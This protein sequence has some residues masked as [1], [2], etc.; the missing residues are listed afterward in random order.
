[1][2]NWASHTVVD[3]RTECKKRDLPIKG[4]KAELVARLE[5]ADNAQQNGTST[6]ASVD[7]APVPPTPLRKS[8][9]ST[10]NAAIPATSIKTNATATPRRS[11]RA[12]IA[13][14]PANEDSSASATPARG[15]P[16][17][18]AKDVKEDATAALAA[19]TPAKTP[20][21]RGSRTAVVAPSTTDRK[22]TRLTRRATSNYS[23]NQVTS[24]A[25]NPDASNDEKD[26]SAEVGQASAVQQVPTSPH[27]ANRAAA[28]GDHMDVDAKLDSIAP[29]N[30]SSNA[31]KIDTNTRT[32]SATLKQSASNG[33]VL[34]SA[35]RKLDDGDYALEASPKKAKAAEETVPAPSKTI[36]SPIQASQP[37]PLAENVKK[38]EKTET[39]SAA[40]VTH[41]PVELSILG[42]AT[43]GRAA[44]IPEETRSVAAAPTEAERPAC[45]PLVVEET[46]TSSNQTLMSANSN[47]SLL[48]AAS[49]ASF[50][51]QDV[52]EP[53]TTIWIKNFTRPLTIPAVKELLSPFGTVEKFW[54]DKIK[55]NCYVT[56]DS[57]EGATAAIQHCH[58]LKFPV[59][60]GRQLVCEYVTREQ[61]DEAIAAAEARTARPFTTVPPRSGFRDERFAASVSGAGRMSA[62][63][64]PP[65]AAQSGRLVQPSSV[66]LQE[67]VYTPPPLPRDAIPSETVF[68]KTKTHPP[69]Y[70]RPRTVTEVLQARQRRNDAQRPVSRRAPP[71]LVRDK[72]G[73]EDEQ[74]QHDSKKPADTSQSRAA[75]HVGAGGIGK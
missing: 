2:T 61:A 44:S 72:D 57:V 24:D 9:R 31:K 63:F 64:I 70:Y 54:M 1:M 13:A 28:D 37:T 46:R 50:A 51:N 41:T 74:R 47:A 16:S 45:A 67:P 25:S 30:H 22:S 7:T 18:A 66:T 29:S 38:G 40:I 15:N 6:T 14:T 58:G 23:E 35:K 49:T 26:L 11:S 39:A 48:T 19:A 56:Y 62:G 60:T 12:T 68:S 75:V 20:A 32:E 69:I 27:P 8:S 3:L 33:D 52:G 55:S 43:R 4:L 34:P 42:A 17:L 53:G 5:E 36:S 71:P 21:R 73:R 65:P 10:D 59:E